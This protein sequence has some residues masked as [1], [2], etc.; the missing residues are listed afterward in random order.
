MSIDNVYSKATKDERF[1]VFFYKRM[2]ILKTM[3]K[4]KNQKIRERIHKQVH[5]YYSLPIFHIS[6]IA[7]Q[8]VGFVLI[9]LSLILIVFP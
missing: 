2:C 7:N 4:K 3:R 9:V 5:K 6:K 1:F 8:L